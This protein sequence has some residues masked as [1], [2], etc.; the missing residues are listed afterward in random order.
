MRLNIEISEK[1]QQE[2]KN[3]SAKNNVSIKDFITNLIEDKIHNKEIKN[4]KQKNNDKFVVS[5]ICG[6]MSQERGISLNSARSVADNLESDKIKIR[7]FFVDKNKNFYEIDRQQL[8]SNT[9]NDFD[10]KLNQNGKFLT[11]QQFI[12]ALQ[13]TDITFPLI[14]GCYGEDGE[15]QKLLENNGVAFVG[16]G[17]IACANGFSKVSATKIL[18]QNGFYAFPF[19][20]F[21]E[22]KKENEIII[23]RFFE[24]NKLKKAVV[25]PS[26][27][28]S[29]IG[30]YCVYSYQEAIE[31][32]NLLLKENPN[33]YIMVEPFCAGR[34][35]TIIVLQNL[36][37]RKPV[38]L[39][40]TE[41]E[42]KYENYQIFDYRRKYLP[43]EQTR[44]Y[45]PAR[46]TDEEIEKIQKYAEDIFTLF[47]FSDMIRMDGWLLNDGRIWFSDINIAAGM[48]QNSFVFQQATRVGFSHKSL[49]NYIVKSA[50]LRY[51]L[52][53]PE[54]E[55]DN[56]K[57]Q[58]VYVLFGGSNAERQ[59][60]L[61]SGSN[62]WL[63]LLG[64]K[65]Y[66]PT[67]FLLDKENNVWQL[68]YCYVL[69]HTVEEIFEH[70]KNSKNDKKNIQKHIDSVC[71]K[72]NIDKFEMQ[73]P[74]EMSFDN[75]IKLSQKNNAFVF[76]ALH[77]GKG[78][79]G[80]IQSEFEKHNIIYNGSNEKAS[81]IAMDKYKT[82]E[83]ITALKDKTLLSAPKYKFY[84]KDFNNFSNQ[85]YQEF[86]KKVAEKFGYSS[87]IIKP[88]NDGSSAGV[89]R[90]YDWS[91]LKTYIETLNNKLPYIP[92]HTFQQQNDIIEVPS[93]IEQPFLLESFID[94][95]ELLIKDD[96]IEY[97]KNTGWL[98]LTV[99][100]V[101]KDGVYHSFNPSITIAK[102]KILSIE[103]KFQGGT[104]VNITPPPSDIIDKNLIKLIKTNIEKTA[105]ALDLKNYA[106][107][108]IFVNVIEKK[109]IIIEANS[110]PALTPSTVIFHQALEEQPKMTPREFIES[111]I[112]STNIK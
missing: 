77:G 6:G 63:K 81:K 76:I 2:I 60:S 62:V 98:E 110:L 85:Q 25:K 21:S 58:N 36:D 101:E 34:E 3:Y 89:V 79:D 84:I 93:N 51:G 74:V 14:H 4:I 86:W 96:R 91:E 57:K 106:R 32:V 112:E 69:N 71:K 80:T 23:K 103:E 13:E 18:T 78:E 12:K 95:D 10:F 61:M 42:M 19:V 100:V 56:S 54:Q 38:A 66:N 9:T 83:I 70:C 5:I 29:S 107:I 111:I 53:F 11:E 41:I 35:F 55:I 90:I 88:A 28:G 40:P 26:N 97:N 52:N 104:G 87:F 59:V 47:D 43:T 68:P 82:G 75:F 30:V 109:V 92:A 22:N 108:D 8:Y 45:T 39:I 37:N 1:L 49:I 72:L 94:T 16:S 64:S 65:K 102:N 73:N 20:C 99:G 44:Y 31:K 67:P 33:D 50:C 48:E 46:F 15:L 27:G 105:K 24:L 17:S 7:V